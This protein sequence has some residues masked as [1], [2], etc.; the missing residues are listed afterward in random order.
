MSAEEEIRKASK[1][2]YS[3]LNKMVNGNTDPMGEIWL[4]EETSTAMHPIG[5][6]DTGWNAVKQSFEQV[7][8]LASDGNVEL[9]D[10]LIHAAG[11]LAYEIGIEAGHA[12]LAGQKVSFNHRVTNIYQRKNGTWKMIHHHADISPAMLDVLNKL[13]SEK[14][15]R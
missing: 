9:K 2:F 6:R 15:K 3:A 7:A 1:Q 5:G 13:E 11:E 4:H 12:T 10:Q 14:G 8:G